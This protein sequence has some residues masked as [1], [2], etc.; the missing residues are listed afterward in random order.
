MSKR[1]PPRSPHSNLVLMIDDDDSGVEGV[2]LAST[3]VALDMN[4]LPLPFLSKHDQAVLN[5]LYRE[6]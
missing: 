5:L 4:D 1:R 3:S 6:D 2:E